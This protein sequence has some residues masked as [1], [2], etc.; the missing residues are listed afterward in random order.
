MI[1][2]GCVFKTTVHKYSYKKEQFML[3][4]SLLGVKGGGG[5]GGIQSSEQPSLKHLAVVINIFRPRFS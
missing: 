5:E 4:R 1:F 3:H 2:I